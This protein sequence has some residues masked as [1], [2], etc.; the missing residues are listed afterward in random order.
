VGKIKLEDM[1]KLGSKDIIE[2]SQFRMKNKIIPDAMRVITPYVPLQEY[3]MSKRNRGMNAAEICRL[4]YEALDLLQAAR[5]GS[6]P[7]PERA[8]R[9]Q[10]AGLLLERGC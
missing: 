5:P 10:Q 4:V 9:R 8:A 2:Y 7:A 3:V 6:A 1:R